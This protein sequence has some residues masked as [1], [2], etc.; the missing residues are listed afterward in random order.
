[1][2]TIIK[3]PVEPLSHYKKKRLNFPFQ[4]RTFKG[5]NRTSE[6]HIPLCNLLPCGFVQV[7]SDLSHSFSIWK[8]SITTPVSKYF[9]QSKSEDGDEVT[10]IGVALSMCSITYAQ[11]HPLSFPL[12]AQS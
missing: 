2:N 10:G 9:P 7:Y 3:I 4:G 11:Q 8:K 5:F 6:F 1:M 12:S